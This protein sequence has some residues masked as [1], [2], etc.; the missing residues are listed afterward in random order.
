MGIFRQDPQ[1]FQRPP[2]VPAVAMVTPSQPPQIARSLAM[3]LAVVGMAWPQPNEPA[4]HQQNRNPR[5][6]APLTLVYGQQPPIAGPLSVAELS[7]IRGQWA[8]DKEPRLQFNN[9]YPG[10]RRY[11]A[12]LVLTYGQQPP[13]QGPLT[14]TELNLA[15]RSWDAP[16]QS[17]PQPLPTASWNVAV[18][19]S[20]PPVVAP[21]PQ[22]ATIR[23][24][25]DQPFVYPVSE[26][27]NAGWNVPV[28]VTQVPFS[29]TPYAQIAS[30]QAVDWRAPQRPQSASWLAHQF[31]QQRPEVSRTVLQS[32]IVDV[33]PIQCSESIAP[34]IA[35]AASDNPPIVGNITPAELS[36]VRQ[37]WEPARPEPPQTVKVAPLTLVYGQNPP[38]D[39][40][41][42]E[43][44]LNLLVTPGIWWPAQQASPNASWNVPVVS[45]FLPFT[46]TPQSVLNAWLPPD[47][48]AQS[49]GPIAPLTLG[50]GDQPQVRPALSVQQRTAIYAPRESWSAQS[51]APNAGWNVPVVSAFLP[52]ARQRPQILASWQEPWRRENARNYVAPLIVTASTTVTGKYKPEHDSALVDIGNATGFS[53]EH[54]SALTD[55]A[56]ATGFK[57]EHDSALKDIKDAGV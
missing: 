48:S 42:S 4:L 14:N 5:Q 46:R 30:W 35:P 20:V 11:I 40:P 27:D 55:I 16:F 33:V 56:N 22:L 17:P 53:A 37:S 29:Q 25:W 2:K 43:V 51:V 47:N 50:Y 26:S 44:E 28:V 49:R 19:V 3:M 23:A 18:A 10:N 15:V 38:L 7:V 32:W 13:I 39:G 12:P 36:V 31:V 41:L 34:A 9:Q 57:P 1:P 24:Q 21:L 8:E 52:N 6:I 45:G 54:S